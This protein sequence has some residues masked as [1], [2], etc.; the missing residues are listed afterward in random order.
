MLAAARPARRPGLVT[1]AGWRLIAGIALALGAAASAAVAL[2]GADLDHDGVEDAQDRCPSLPE[3]LGA[4]LPA[5]GCPDSLGWLAMASPDQRALLTSG[6]LAAALRFPFSG[7]DLDPEGELRLKQLSRRLDL[8]PSGRALQLVVHAS[9]DEPGELAA[10]RCAVVRARLATEGA[11]LAG[12]T[13]CLDLGTRAW[14]SGGVPGG[15]L[16]VVVVSVLPV[17]GDGP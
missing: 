1:R 11:R 14:R 13:A 7:S 3:T 9:P 6:Q 16:E 12:R 17:G 2:A 8:D 10:Q 5:D 4:A 15:R